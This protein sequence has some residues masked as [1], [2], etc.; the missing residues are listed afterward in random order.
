MKRI[1]KARPWIDDNGKK[2]PDE[3]LKVIS[4]G[5][6]QKTWDYYLSETVDV[7]QREP[8]LKEK[9]DVENY[10]QEDHSKFFKESFGKKH[11]PNL[12]SA[13]NVMIGELP[14]KEAIILRMLFNE[15]LGT[16]KTAKILKIDDSSVRRLRKKGLELL[17]EK[18]KSVEDNKKL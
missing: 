13:L 9:S 15:G 8:I 5:W 11:R 12:K 1:K 16:R 14:Q 3:K 17:K 7:P 2:Y 10:S 4:K 6:D 18:F